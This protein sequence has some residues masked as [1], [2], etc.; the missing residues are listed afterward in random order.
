MDDKKI[1]IE[2]F[3]KEY[4]FIVIK[5]VVQLPHL[6]DHYYAVMGNDKNGFYEASVFVDN[7]TVLI[8]PE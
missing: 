5:D 8:L 2:D 1:I 7:N 4:P 3:A 6:G